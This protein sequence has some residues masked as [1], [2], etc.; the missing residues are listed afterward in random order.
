[1]PGEMQGRLGKYVESGL[2]RAK[3]TQA[4]AARQAGVTRAWL[5]SVMRGGTMQPDPAKL[6]RL[7]EAVPTLELDR[8]LA[9]SDQLGAALEVRQ[10][11]AIP[12]ADMAA[13]ADAINAQTKVLQGI[14][15]RLGEL[16]EAQ[17]GRDSVLAR[18][19]VELARQ[20][21]P[22]GRLDATALMRALAPREPETRRA[23]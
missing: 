15:E 22:E 16:A 23:P 18:L 5:V 4:E 6:R 20:V 10:A 3:V 2:L 7:A 14:A 13:I 1:M 19:M 21:A 11:R 8:M 9:L 17:Q 12:N